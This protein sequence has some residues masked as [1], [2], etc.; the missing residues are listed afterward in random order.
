MSARR[1]EGRV[2]RRGEGW[3]P[4]TATDSDYPLTVLG[5]AEVGRVDLLQV[6]P[7]ASF[8]DGHQK[9]EDT[10]PVLAGQET[11]DILEYERCGPQAGDQ[12]GEPA[13]ERV[14]PV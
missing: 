1:A 11:F 6:D 9:V 10:S 13:H 5:H 14:A 4:P 8:D 7:V 3:V 2:G 12:L